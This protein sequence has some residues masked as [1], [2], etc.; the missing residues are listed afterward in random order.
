MLTS[1]AQNNIFLQY[2]TAC[3]YLYNTIDIIISV[4]NNNI[5][6]QQEIGDACGPAE[7]TRGGMFK[8]IWNNVIGLSDQYLVK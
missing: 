1:T 5:K 3:T 8:C 4:V 2:L 6:M 7:N